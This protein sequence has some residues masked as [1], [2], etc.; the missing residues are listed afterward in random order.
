MKRILAVLMSVMVAAS[1]AVACAP[2][3]KSDPSTDENRDFDKMDIIAVTPLFDS[4]VRALSVSE[5]EYDAASSK[6]VWET[7]YLV[8]NNY[9]YGVV[10]DYR[11]TLDDT[12]SDSNP[13]SPDT[14]VNEGKATLEQI[15]K[16]FTACFGANTAL[17]DMPEGFDALT[18][19][20]GEYVVNP[21]DPATGTVSLYSYNFTSDSECEAVI[22][23]LDEKGERI[24]GYMLVVTTNPDEESPYPLC[25]TKLAKYSIKDQRSRSN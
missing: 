25:I 5:G 14:T 1:F 16:I 8:L 9:G 10:E 22:E 11:K 7:I 24:G 4:L 20:D 21:S 13:Q 12:T 23:E 17:P 18:L 19:V 2:E 15:E 3:D 6:Y